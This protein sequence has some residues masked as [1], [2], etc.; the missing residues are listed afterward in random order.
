MLPTVLFVAFTG[1]AAVGAFLI[2]SHFRSRTAG[3][4]AAVLV[5]VF[6][7]ALYAYLGWL[8]RSAGL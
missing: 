7:V 2:G 6:M 5:V 1:L 3:V 8:A 4:V